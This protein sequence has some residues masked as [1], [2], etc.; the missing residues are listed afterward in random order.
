MVKRHYVAAILLFLTGCAS[1]HMKQYMGRD[2]REVVIDSGP[3]IHAFDMGDSR[4]AF[5][6]HWG[7]GTIVVPQTT[8]TT[9]SVTAIGNTAWFS[10]QAITS[11]GGV[12]QVPPCIITYL[13]RWNEA[14]QAWTV[15]DYRYP[16][17]LVC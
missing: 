2:I 3:P 7:G 9:G 15:V 4:R 1:T 10:S 5:Q 13:T 17:Q 12:V 6:F 8:T 11:P 14:S 16:K